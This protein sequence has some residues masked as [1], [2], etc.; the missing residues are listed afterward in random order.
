MKELTKP[1]RQLLRKD[2]DFVWEQAQQTAFDKIKDVITKEPVLAY[3]D[4]NKPI[5]IQTDSS[6]Y[7]L[8]CVLLQD[9]K[10]VCFGLNNIYSDKVHDIHKYNVKTVGSDSKPAAYLD[11]LLDML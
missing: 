1:M 6:K 9:G 8:G 4:Y 5:T 7:G 3:F 11:H 10:P 2:V